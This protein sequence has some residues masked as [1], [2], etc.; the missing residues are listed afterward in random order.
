M[1]LEIAESLIY[2]YLKHVEGCRIFNKIEQ[3]AP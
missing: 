2:S 3:T 1:K